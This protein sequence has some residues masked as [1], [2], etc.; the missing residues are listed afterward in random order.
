MNIK[1]GIVITDLQAPFQDQLSLLAVERYMKDNK[2]DYYINLGDHLDYFSISRFNEGKP[3]LI[4]QQTILEEC[5]AGERILRRH[6]AIIRGKNKAAKMYLI[7]GN[8]EH[9]ATAYTQMF[10]HFQGLIE[11]PVVLGLK[12]KRI[13]YIKSWSEGKVLSIGKA[14]F[15]HGEYTNT[16]HAKKMVEAYEDNIF[17]GH[18]HDCNAYNKTAKGTGK[19]KVGQ[20]LG[21]LCEY[22]IGVD[23]TRGKA[24]NWQQAV[25]TF[26]F[27][28]DGS[29]NYYISR[30]FDHRFVAPDGK[31]YDGNRS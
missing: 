22:P 26:Y 20:A 7:E 1:K 25:S 14:N 5:R 27:F 6:A 12:E 17:Y 2:W 19:T 24:K 23:Y 10:P 16:H 21:C 8:H 4:G 18:T 31:V 15:T 13:E 11:A 30:I 29:F 3:G 9:R 28:E